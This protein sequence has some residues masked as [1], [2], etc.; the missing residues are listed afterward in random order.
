MRARRVSRRISAPSRRMKPNISR[1]FAW[2]LGFLLTQRLRQR[3]AQ[4]NLR[5]FEVSGVLSVNQQKPNPQTVAMC[6]IRDPR[7]TKT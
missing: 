2:L 3:I 4:P 6:P 7:A 5:V 1:V